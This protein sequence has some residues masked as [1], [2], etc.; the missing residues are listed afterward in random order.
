M[1]VLAVLGFAGLLLQAQ[2]P[3]TTN[4]LHQAEEKLHAEQ[5]DAAEAL[6]QQAVRQTP[7]DTEVLYR[8]GYVQYRQRKLA[9]ARANFAAVVK[10]A[11]PAYHSR[12]FL[13][14]IA[15]LENKPKEAI[16]WLEPVA[17]SGYTNFD[18]ASQLAK[19]YADAGEPGKAVPALKTAI[20]QAPWD[21]ALYYRLGQ[22]YRQT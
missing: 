2:P 7:A 16:E 1:Q 14:R 8:L 4:L 19:A 20:G 17:A 12:Y 18:A 13:G 22:L 9:P 6:L 21:G 10:L 11:P 3:A 15:I 5:L